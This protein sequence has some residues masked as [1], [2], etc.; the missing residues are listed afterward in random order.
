VTPSAYAE[1]VL[2]LV[3]AVPPGRVVTYGD[4]A[5]A[6]GRGGPRQV[7]TVM[8]VWGAAVPWHRVVRADGRPAAGHEQRALAL[9]AAEGCPL[10]ADGARVRMT[11]ARWTPDVGPGWFDHGSDEE[12]GP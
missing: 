3:E 11:Q 7:G 8:A 12:G 10:T 4:V 9:L 5:A 1:A 6:L 2:T